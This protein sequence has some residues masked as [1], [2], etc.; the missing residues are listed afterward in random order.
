MFKQIALLAGL[1]LAGCVGGGGTGEIGEASPP[2]LIRPTS[3]YGER[4]TATPY[5]AITQGPPVD[6]GGAVAVPKG[7]THTEPTP[8]VTSAPIAVQGDAGVPP[9]TRPLTAVAAMDMRP[10]YVEMITAALFQPSGE[11]GWAVNLKWCLS[12]SVDRMDIVGPGPTAAGRLIYSLGGATPV[13]VE[14]PPRPTKAGQCVTFADTWLT[15]RRERGYKFTFGNHP[16]IYVVAE[17]P[18]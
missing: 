10:P 5:E 2:E 4:Q 9:D 1:G 7:E 16:D 12:F 3:P 15:P 6:A 18:N 14:Q 17:T 13:P 8:P 11:R